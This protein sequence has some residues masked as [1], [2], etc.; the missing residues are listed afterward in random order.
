MSAKKYRAAVDLLY[1]VIRNGQAKPWV[2]GALNLAL[3]MDKAPVK[4][5][6]RA[7]LSSAPYL[8]S[9]GERFELGRLLERMGSDRRAL[10]FYCEVCKMAPQFTEAYHSGIRLAHALNDEKSLKELTICI[11]S[12]SWNGNEM[13]K[14]WLRGSELA[15]GLATKMR[16]ENRNQEADE[17]E[18]ALRK[19]T[20]CDCVV[21]FEYSGDAE[22]DISVKEPA[23]TICWFGSPRTF[24]GGVLG[25]NRL[26]AGQQGVKSG[27]YAC[28]VGFSGTY[29]VLIERIWGNVAANRVRVT[30]YTHYGTDRATQETKYV[31][32]NEEGMGLVRFQLQDGRR[33]ESIDDAELAALLEEA[34]RMRYAGEV[35][36]NLRRTQSRNVLVDTVAANTREE[37]LKKQQANRDDAMLLVPSGTV[38]GNSPQPQ[39]NRR[40]IRVS[41]ESGFQSVKEV[42]EYGK[43][44]R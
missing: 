11:A 12:Q 24:A 14:I 28:P 19:A 3:E 2:Y 13:R 16:A 34:S 32:L 22:V 25:Q 42:T 40:I 27:N 21:Y 37:D 43:P 20:Q 10:Q 5:R 26:S 4:E 7:I 29:E 18:A 23:N 6:E 33:T 38:I 31:P 17:Y 39:G 41:P 1:A 9:P 30:V 44:Q 35:S 15:K 36:R 8:A